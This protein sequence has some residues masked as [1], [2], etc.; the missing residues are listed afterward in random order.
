MEDKSIRDL[1][2]QNTQ[3][4][5]QTDPKITQYLHF[6]KSQE[7]GCEG[8]LSVCLVIDNI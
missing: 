3:F 1:Q 5:H 7:Q 6:C 2:V 4:A 8:H